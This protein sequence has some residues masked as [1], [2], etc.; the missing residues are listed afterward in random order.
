LE[1]REEEKRGKMNIKKTLISL[2]FVILGVLFIM[3]ALNRP[4]DIGNI[5]QTIG[6]Q[7]A[8]VEQPEEM[9]RMYCLSTDAVALVCTLLGAASI[10]PGVSGVHKGLTE[11]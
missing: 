3:Y 10:F 8:V 2:A 6:D 11:D 5:T 9:N 4:C 1:I 7:T